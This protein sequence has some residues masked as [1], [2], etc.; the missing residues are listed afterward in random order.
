[1]KNFTLKLQIT[2]GLKNRW[3]WISLHTHT[4]KDDTILLHLACPTSP[5]FW[6]IEFHKPREVKWCNLQCLWKFSTN[7]GTFY[8]CCLWILTTTVSNLTEVSLTIF[9]CASSSI[10]LLNF[11][12]RS[13]PYRSW[14]NSLKTTDK[15]VRL[16]DC[17]GT[18]WCFKE[19]LFYPTPKIVCLQKSKF[20]IPPN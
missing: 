2:L 20:H 1:M 6:Q 17:V 11:R 7:V 12:F 4:K 14:M 5:L 13:I 19:R 8:F 9:L 10:F 15:P 16:I 18:C 3:C